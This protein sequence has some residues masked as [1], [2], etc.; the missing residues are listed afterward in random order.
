MKISEQI[1]TLSAIFLLLGFQ[2]ANSQVD[3]KSSLT[4]KEIMAKNYVGQAPKGVQWSQDSKHLFFRWKKSDAVSD[5]AYQIT[6]DN[7]IPVRIDASIISD[8]KPARGIFSSGR[9]L[10]L[11]SDK[12]GLNLIKLKKKDTSRFFFSSD[13]VS[14]LKFSFDESKV[15][16]TIENNLFWWDISS[17][18]YR[19]LTNFQ[20]KKEEKKKVTKESRNEQDEWLYNEQKEL[21][22]KLS[23]GRNRFSSRNYSSMYGI[24]GRQSSGGPK[25]I[26]LD[27]Q[28]VYGAQLSPDNRFVSY[29]LNKRAESSTGTKIPVYVTSSGYTEIQNARSKVGNLPSEMSI[30]IYDLVKD[31]SYQLSVENL[32]GIFDAPD[33]YKDYPDRSMKY[34][35]PKTVYISGPFWSGDGNFGV[36]TARSAD[37]KDRWI[38]LVNLMNG[39]VKNLDHQ[40]DE[41]WI[42]GPGIGYGG[43]VGWMPDNKRIWFQSEATG[44]S[45]LYT[46]DVTTGKKTAL[47]SGNFEVSRPFMSKNKKYW[48]FSSNEVHPGEKHFYRMPINGGERVQLTSM[49]GSNSVTLSP[50]EKY[51]AIT[52]SFA[53][54]PPELYYQLN[55]AG[56]KAVQLTDSRSEIFKNYNWRVP[57]FITFT[58]EDGTKVYARLYQPQSGVKNNAAVIFV[59]GAGYLQNA[60][61]WWSTYYH[62]FVFNNILVDNGYTVLDID[63]RGSAGYGR[64]C[65]TGIYRWMGGKDLSDQVDGAKLLVNKYGIDTNRIG[66]Y[67]G[68]YGGFLTLM[69]MFNEPDV[70]AA[71]A[72]LRSVTDWAHYNHGYTDNILNTPVEDSIAYAKSSPINFTEGL[73]GDLLMCHGMIDDNVHF[74]DIVRLS[75]RLIDLGKENWEL[76]VFPL[77]RHSFTDPDAWTNEYRR[78]FKLFQTTLGKQ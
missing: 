70:F 13:R 64:D 45:H 47:T 65:R 76:A 28:S 26:F 31:S 77:Q 48:Y 40:H 74:Q 78:I 71:G 16:F 38:F 57:E 52:F 18:E 43:S 15:L 68:S 2:P 58:A 72:A 39:S 9:R 27:G 75:Q 1:L 56:A 32:P 7:L 5:S 55:K 54:R 73:K 34:K 46:L 33:Y 25:A 36:M 51:M 62:E 35:K 22:P 29:T 6:P 63:Y 41:A 60:H 19:Q 30:G 21:F 37:N 59:H 4:I 12:N 49:V 53:N 14:G 24:Y 66:L 50:D 67:G 17:G 11:L 44:Y 23:K 69:A 42:G 10:Q 8:N 20:D 61:K 3:N